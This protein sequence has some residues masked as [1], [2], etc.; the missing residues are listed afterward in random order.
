M[1]DLDACVSV[2]EKSFR[3]DKDQ[4]H[5]FLLIHLS[6]IKM[7]NESNIQRGLKVGDPMINSLGGWGV[8]CF[9]Q[10]SIRAQF[11]FKVQGGEFWSGGFT[12]LVC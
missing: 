12:F 10:V 7:T 8:E 11:V 4:L 6:L 1:V 9:D 3:Y 2:L 5:Q